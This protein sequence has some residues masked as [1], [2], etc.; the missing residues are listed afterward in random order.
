MTEIDNNWPADFDRWTGMRAWVISINLQAQI[1]HNCYPHSVLT[2]FKLPLPNKGDKSLKTMAKLG[3]KITWCTTSA[4]QRSSEKWHSP[5]RNALHNT[6]T[7][8]GNETS[9]SRGDGNS[10]LT[11]RTEQDNGSLQKYFIYIS[12]T[13]SS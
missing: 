6:Y 12:V 5:I 8:F 1:T 4:A 10:E 9:T 2:D 7:K 3:E 13:N 11:E